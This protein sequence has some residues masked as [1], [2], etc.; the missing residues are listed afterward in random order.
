MPLN[1]EG[2]ATCT[3]PAS[4]A[5][6]YTIEAAYSGDDQFEDSSGSKDHVGGGA[7]SFEST[8]IQVKLI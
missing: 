1:S 7:R 4:P 8:R 2:I 5:G 6:T 3:F